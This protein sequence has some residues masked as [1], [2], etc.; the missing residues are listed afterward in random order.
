[1]SRNPTSGRRP[2]T[3]ERDRSATTAAT[4][5][6]PAKILLDQAF[7]RDGLVM[8]RGAVATHAG[9]LGMPRETVEHLILA[10]YELASNAVRHGGGRGRLTLAVA[11]GTLRCTVTDE[12]PGFPDAQQ[13]GRVRPDPGASGGRG[14]WLARCVSGRLDVRSGAGGT[15]AVAEFPLT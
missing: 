5:S 8:L 7:D 12:G 3:A 11:D 14:L 15:V 6:G 9:A 2:V 1:M 4:G 10:A 13:A